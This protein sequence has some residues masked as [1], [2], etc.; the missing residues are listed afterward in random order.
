MGGPATNAAPNAATQDLNA[1]IAAL[2]ES[3]QRAGASQDSIDSVVSNLQS[4]AGNQVTALSDANGDF[5]FPD[6]APGQ[7]TIRAQR[8]GYFGPVANGTAPSIQTKSIALESGKTERA[9]FSL[10]KG[11]VISGRV[12]NPSGNAQTNNYVAVARVGYASNGRLI[13][14]TSGNTF[15]DDQGGF[16]LYW[17][18]PGDYFVGGAARRTAFRINGPIRSTPA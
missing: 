16:R 11:G 8:E 17:L 3:G 7:Y 18:P 4:Q 2:I 13:W 10:V 15:S 6:L 9:D 14:L 5:S 1:R 12:R